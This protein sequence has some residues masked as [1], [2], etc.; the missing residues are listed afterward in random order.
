MSNRKPVRICR[1]TQGTQTGL[2]D[3]LE[4][5]GGL[6]DER[7]VQEGGDICIPIAESC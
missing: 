3:N 2:C 5:W 6:G 4:R 7:K 1:M